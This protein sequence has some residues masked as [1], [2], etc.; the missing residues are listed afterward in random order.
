MLR[1]L[2][3]RALKFLDDTFWGTVPRRRVRWLNYDSGI[4]PVKK[5]HN[6]TN[7][8]AADTHGEAP[9]PKSKLG[10]YYPLK[11][12]TRR[13]EIVRERQSSQGGGIKAGS[14]EANADSQTGTAVMS[15]ADAASPVAKGGSNN[16]H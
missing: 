2:A 7:G 3:V 1:P 8:A 10:Y 16:G 15:A 6:G 13:F 4:L 14:T 5:G 9:D 12:N 11:E